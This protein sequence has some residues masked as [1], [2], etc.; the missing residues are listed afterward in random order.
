MSEFEYPF[1]TTGTL[2]SN[3][4]V[5]EFQTLTKPN[6]Y[7]YYVIIPYRGPFYAESLIVKFNGNELTENV[8]YYPC[9]HYLGASRSIGK[10]IYGGIHFPSLIG[11]TIEIT[12]QTIGGDWV[13]DSNK[14]LENLATMVYNPR[15]I[16]YDEVT[17][18]PSCFPPVIHPID[19]NDV[20][21]QGDVITALE[22]IINAVINRPSDSNAAI[23]LTRLSDLESRVARLESI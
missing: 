3:L 23:I 1:D 20:T 9:L 14:V 19:Y 13:I 16:V 4:I 5:G 10:P 15:T 21:G 11:G 6:K 18:T 12:Y 8:D 17:A 22:G 2:E 7:D